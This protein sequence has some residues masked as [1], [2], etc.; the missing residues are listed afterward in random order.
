MYIHLELE[1]GGGGP[2]PYKSPGLCSTHI[3][4]SIGHWSNVHTF[5]KFDQKSDKFLSVFFFFMKSKLL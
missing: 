2:I 3:T 4:E 5:E 1:T